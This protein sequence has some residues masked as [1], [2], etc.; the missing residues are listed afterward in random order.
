MT[1]ELM[2][3]LVIIGIVA[4]L[5]YVAGYFVGNAHGEQ[6]ARDRRPDIGE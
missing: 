3:V 6:R 4:V 1:T 5:F 2:Q